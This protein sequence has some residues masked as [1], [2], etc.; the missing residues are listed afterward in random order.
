MLEAENE[1]SKGNVAKVEQ[2]LKPIRE[3][4]RD[5]SQRYDEIYTVQTR[6]G[7]WFTGRGRGVGGAV[8]NEVVGVMFECCRDETLL[9]QHSFCSDLIDI[10]EKYF[11]GDLL[12][13]VFKAVSLD[14][15]F[16]FLKEI[17][18]FYNL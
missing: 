1:A 10:R 8:V 17:N 9:L 16:N 13:M 3:R 18:V 15:I 2:Q 14:I 7:E 5:I 4:L 12:R 6:I 11:N